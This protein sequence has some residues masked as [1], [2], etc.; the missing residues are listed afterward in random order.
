MTRD[1]RSKCLFLLPNSQRGDLK[2]SWYHSATLTTESA[3]SAGGLMVPY[4]V[5]GALAPVRAEDSALR[6]HSTRQC[7]TYLAVASHVTL[8]QGPTQRT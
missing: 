1:E 4:T 6:E 8:G 3:T 5:D 7:R 2:P